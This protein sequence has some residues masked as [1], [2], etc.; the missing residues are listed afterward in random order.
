MIKVCTAADNKCTAIILNDHMPI[1]DEK[2]CI[3]VHPMIFAMSRITSLALYRMSRQ[4]S[5]SRSPYIQAPYIIHQIAL[6]VT[7]LRACLL[8]PFHVALL[9]YTHPSSFTSP[10]M[11]FPHQHSKAVHVTS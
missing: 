3:S 5:I 6:H 4:L 9:L 2:R 7:D 11:A 10:S 1:R 8:T